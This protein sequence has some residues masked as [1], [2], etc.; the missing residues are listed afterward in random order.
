MLSILWITDYSLLQ[1]NKDERQHRH[2]TRNLTKVLPAAIK[3]KKRCHVDIKENLCFKQSQMNC[4]K[5]AKKHIRL[6]VNSTGLGV[7][8]KLM[9]RFMS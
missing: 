9:R 8:P 2:L 3:N 5:N 1:S 6:P 4:I 7:L